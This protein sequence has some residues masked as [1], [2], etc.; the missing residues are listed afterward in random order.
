MKDRQWIKADY[1]DTFRCKQGACR[2]F[3]CQGWEIAVGMEDY[4]RMIGMDCPDEL[5]H[6][7]ECAFRTPEFPAP[8]RYRL[9]SP[10]YLGR[11]P[12]HDESG[13][14][15]LQR[16]LGEAFMPEICRVYPRSLKSV[17]G[18]RRA[19][20]S[21]SCEA[22]VE[23]LMRNEPLEFATGSLEAE[24]ELSMEAGEE[25]M[26]LQ[27][28]C[29]AALRRRDMPL[30]A[31]IGAIGRLIGWQGDAVYEGSGWEEILEVLKVEE[32]NSSS[33]TRWGAAALDRYGDGGAGQRLCGDIARMEQALPHWSLWFEN[34]LANHF[35]Y[36]CFPRVDARLKPADAF[37]GLCLLY[38]YMRVLAAAQLA[39]HCGEADFADVMAGIFRAVEHSP[40]YYNARVL[41]KNPQSLLVV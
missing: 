29:L 32:E 17:G 34:I 8:E 28:A 12:L 38:G 14:C 13:L 41:L 7:L 6:R 39:V 15:M 20:C 27:G 3:C 4:F 31:R 16:D 1:Y 35:F 19:C 9:I 21:N 30:S 23:R 2:N 37:Y 40:F 11:C 10:N 5:H 24:V 25:E 18:E 36:E 22:V 33:L 26:A